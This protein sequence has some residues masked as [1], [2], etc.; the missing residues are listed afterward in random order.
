MIL[1]L[2]DKYARYYDN[3]NRLYWFRR[4]ILLS[5]SGF[6]L[7]GLALANSVISM[8]YVFGHLSF[9]DFNYCSQSTYTHYYLL[10]YECYQFVLLLPV[11]LSLV[12]MVLM[13]L[14][15]ALCAACCPRVL[16]SCT[17]R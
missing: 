15:A 2:L 10:I 12:G 16:G 8:V 13:K 1:K 3:S 4:S 9:R 5:W 14:G 6:V 7:L 17:C 11:L